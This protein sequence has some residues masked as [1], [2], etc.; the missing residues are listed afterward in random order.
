[1]ESASRV[2]QRAPIVFLGLVALLALASCGTLTGIPAHGGGKRFATEQ[3]L[4]SASIRAA[5][6]DIDVTALRGKRAA[7]VFDLVADEGGG[8]LSGGR[9][10]PGLLFS[11]GSVLSP[12]TTTNSAFQ[13]FN[14]AESGGNYSNSGSSGG[15][16]TASTT[17]QN[18]SN[19]NSGSSTQQSDSSSSGTTTNTSNTTNAGTSSGTSTSTT[20][21][22]A[23]NSN[24]NQTDNSTNATTGSGTNT[25]DT[26]TTGSGTNNSTGSN[27]GSSSTTSTS[28]NNGGSTARGG[29]NSQRQTVSQT[30]SETTSVTEGIRRE[31]IATLQYKGLGDYQN[32]NVPK[33]DASLLMG[34]VRNYLLFSGVIPTTPTDP[35]AEVLVY[36]TVDIFGTVRSR[37]DALVYNNET[38]K[39]ETSFE[40]SA[41]DRAGN[42]IMRP[43]VANR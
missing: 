31:H 21:G 42:L 18:G 30:P 20:G 23:T 1:M 29:F 13:V 8:S 5:L 15:T 39:A 27:S 38:V 16:T 11:A 2:G 32:F 36:I 41:F 35:N 12:V 43:Q 19:T 6:K 10:T 26:S 33:S 24:F 7:L 34:L 14:L 28:S 40:I 17:L 9:W 37:F 25:Q 3:R 22:T 4:V